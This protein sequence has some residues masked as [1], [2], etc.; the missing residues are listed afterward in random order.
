MTS[1]EALEVKIKMLFWMGN[2]Y[3]VPKRSIYLITPSSVGFRNDDKRFVPIL[4]FVGERTPFST[5]S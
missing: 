4:V 5:S 3:E 2:L 1:Y